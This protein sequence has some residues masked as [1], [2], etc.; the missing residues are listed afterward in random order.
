VQGAAA[1][2]QQQ[3]GRVPV[4]LR[5][6]RIALGVIVQPPPPNESINVSGHAA[7]QLGMALVGELFNP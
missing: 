2:L 4:L 5:N 1:S 3:Q 7:S 6:R